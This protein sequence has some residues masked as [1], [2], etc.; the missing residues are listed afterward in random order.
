LLFG[1][2][3]SFFPR[4]WHREIFERQASAL[5]QIG[6]AAAEASR[7]LGGNLEALLADTKPEK[8]SQAAALQ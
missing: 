1:T 7:I 6:T 2:D 3:S 4:G 5:Y 8:P